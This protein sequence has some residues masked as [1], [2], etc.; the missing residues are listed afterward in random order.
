M[1]RKL[2]FPMI[3]TVSKGVVSFV[4]VCSITIC[5]HATQ[6]HGL[7]ASIV[8]IR[9]IDGSSITLKE[10]EMGLA[11]EKVVVKDGD[12]V[13][14]LLISN[15]I[16]ADAESIGVVYDLNPNLDAKSIRSTSELILP[17][18]T[19]GKELLHAFDDGYMAFLTPDKEMKKHFFNNSKSLEGLT[20]NISVLGLHLFENAEYKEKFTKS[21]AYTIESLDTIGTVIKTRGRHFSSEVLRQ[22]NSETKLLST[23]LDRAILE[24]RKLSETDWE[25]IKLIEEDMQIKMR[26]F[27]EKMGPGEL[28][29]RWREAI[30]V[31]RT[32]NVYTGNEVHN[33][34]VYYVPV[35]LYGIGEE[36]TFDQ[37]TSP[38]EERMLPEANYRIW[39]GNP[40]DTAPL[41]DIKKLKVR[42]TSKEKKILVEL[43][44][45]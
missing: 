25:R 41:S 9:P 6:T 42:K 32:L 16:Y 17:K 36:D 21:V 26:A 34:R 18:V 39:A 14:N 5:T 31:V 15:G 23:I 11:T 37:V 20:E 29:P 30:V 12:S 27:D 43:T 28:P 8:L 3:V 19:G 7:D 33:L 10:E 24:D 40:G 45:N 44:I 2:L 13:E 4:L 38:T 22:I 35:A 1:R